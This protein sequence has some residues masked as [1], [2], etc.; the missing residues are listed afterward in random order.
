VAKAL[1]NELSQRLPAFDNLAGP[2]VLGDPRAYTYQDVVTVAGPG[3]VLDLLIQILGSRPSTFVLVVKKDG[4][5][6]PSLSVSSRDQLQSIKLAA[7][8][9]T[10]RR[11][12]E[13]AQLKLS[14]TLVYDGSSKNLTAGACGTVYTV[15]NE[16]IL[17]VSPDGLMTA[18]SSGEAQVKASNEHFS[19][20]VTIKVD[21]S[22]AKPPPTPSAGG[23][24]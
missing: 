6:G 24:P 22:E 1:A 13:M 23:L 11:Q 20:W 7:S 17:S 9:T 8:T 21:L 10:L 15:S 19:D 18:R 4:W 3:S 12:D 14:G 2:W 16:R 5:L